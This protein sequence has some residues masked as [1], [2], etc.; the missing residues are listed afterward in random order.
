MSTTKRRRVPL[1]DEVCPQI[2]RIVQKRL[3]DNDPWLMPERVLAERLHVSRTVIR[4]A[5]QRLESEGMVE[6]VHGKGIKAVDKLQRPVNR[7]IA[8]KIP[9]VEKRLQ[10]LAEVRLILEPEVARGAALMRTTSD[11]QELKQIQSN[12]RESKLPEEAVQFDMDFHRVLARAAG[13]AVTE[14]ILGSLADLGR[15][16]RAVTISRYGVEPAHSQH[17]RVLQA[18]EA[19]EA[20]RAAAAMRAHIQQALKDLKSS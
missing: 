10:Q 13:N 2:I 11:L 15:E 4:E 1:V 17:E 8:L 5:I 12:L 7:S 20:D 14:L 3:K 19:G 18:V 6:V 9:D 16:S